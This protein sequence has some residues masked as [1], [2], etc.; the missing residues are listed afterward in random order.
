MTG[1]DREYLANKEEYLKLFDSAMQKEQEQN[2]ES[3]VNIKEN[4]NVRFHFLTYTFG[5]RYNK[6]K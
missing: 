4:L 6:K 5:N 1:W 3:L 2:V